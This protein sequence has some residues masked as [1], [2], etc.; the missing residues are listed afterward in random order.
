MNPLF[1]SLGGAVIGAIIGSFVGALAVR[2]PERSIASGRSACDG[3]GATLRPWELVPLLSYV[4]LRGRCARC[5]SAIDARQPLAELGGA[6]VGA[7]AL[8]VA[9]G[10]PGLA[11]ALFGWALMALALLDARHFWLPDRI[12][13]PLAAAGLAL[14]LP[15]LAERIAGAA[16]GWL[17][18]TLIARAYA[19]ARGRIGL[20]AGDAKLLAAI[21]AWLGWRD[22]PGVVLAACLIGLGW[23]LAAHLRGQAISAATRMPFGTLMALAAFPL[24]LM[25]AA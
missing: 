4:L 25:R 13:L 14:G 6:A 7:A 10:W 1:P 20:G 8:W 9:P 24:W 23:A 22:L 2:W 11:G 18:L 19:R 5:G 21:G 17:A 3:C 15:P 12:T 16:A